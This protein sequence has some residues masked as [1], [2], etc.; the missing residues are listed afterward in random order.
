MH[1][2]NKLLKSTLLADCDRLSRSGSSSSLSEGSC[3]TLRGQRGKQREFFERTKYLQ[4][5]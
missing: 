3:T 5:A 2:N 1:H 4:T